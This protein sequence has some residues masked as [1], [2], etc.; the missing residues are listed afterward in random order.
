M[1]SRLARSCAATGRLG[2]DSI[3]HD[4][5]LAASGPRLAELAHL[6]VPAVVQH[7]PGD[8]RELVGKRDRKLVV[9]HARCG[10]FDPT[11]EAVAFPGLGS[12]P[13][14]HARRLHEEHAQVA[15]A[16][17]GDAAQQRTTTG[18]HLLWHQSEPGAEVASFAEEIAHADSRHGCT[19]DDG[20]NAW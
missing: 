16:A 11:L 4:G 9:M 1:L 17:L 10:G 2:L 20:T 14:D 19:G 3:E 15:I 18:R 6:E 12:Q 8:T 7:A 5:T 13:Q